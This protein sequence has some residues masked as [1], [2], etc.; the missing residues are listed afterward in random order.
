M[1][2][3]TRIGCEVF[4]Q[5]D[6]DY[7]PSAPLEGMSK[8][9]PEFWMTAIQNHEGLSGLIED[10]DEDALKY[11]TDIKLEYT[12][13]PFRSPP[14]RSST[15]SYNSQVVA[16]SKANQPSNVKPGF[17]LLFYFSR[18]PFFYNSLLEKEY[19]YKLNPTPYSGGGFVFDHAVGSIIEWKSDLTK[20]IDTDDNGDGGQ[21][22]KE[23]P[24]YKDSFFKFFSPPPPLSEQMLQAHALSDEELVVLVEELE[25]DLQAGEEIKDDVSFEW[26]TFEQF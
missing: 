5:Q 4:K 18:N 7:E 25:Q 6:P 8:G 10:H 26:L 19:I 24:R 20:I 15:S 16:P 17:K 22:Q 21:N 1:A 2:K 11:L 13:V 14:R 23:G 3:E 12:G 9:V